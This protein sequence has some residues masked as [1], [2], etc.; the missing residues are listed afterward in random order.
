MM[1]RSTSGRETEGGE[2]LEQDL[3][4]LAGGDEARLDGVETPKLAARRGPS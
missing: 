4:V 3:L 2:G 1:P